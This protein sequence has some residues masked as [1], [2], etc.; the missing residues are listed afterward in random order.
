VGR[1]VLARQ[2][3]LYRIGEAGVDSERVNQRDYIGAVTAVVLNET[4]AAVLT[5]GRVQLHLIE[6]VRSSPTLTLGVSRLESVA[7]PQA[8]R[9][10]T[11]PPCRHFK[12]QPCFCPGSAFEVAAIQTQLNEH[13]FVL[14][15]PL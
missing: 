6:E 11:H 2:V 7:T 8:A 4:H 10:W 15:P 9:G 14:S 12:I 13:G 3:W 1:D 5:E